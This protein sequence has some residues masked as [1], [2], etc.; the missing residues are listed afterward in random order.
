[1]AK[2]KSKDLPVL[3]FGGEGLPV[4]RHTWYEHAIAGNPIHAWP[5]DD[6]VIIDDEE[7]DAAVAEYVA[8][9]EKKVKAETGG[10][11]TTRAGRQAIENSKKEFRQYCARLQPR[12]IRRSKV[13]SYI[14]RDMVKSPGINKTPPPKKPAQ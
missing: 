11:I 4:G 1:M 2:K 13:Q 14:D 10:N 7:A 12:L 9:A 3:T 5:G 6:V 8:E